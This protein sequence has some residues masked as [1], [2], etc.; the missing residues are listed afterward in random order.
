MTRKE[1]A[2]CSALLVS[3]Y[4][5]EVVEPE[6]LTLYRESLASF[7]A[8][9]VRQAVLEHIHA[10][11][12]FPKISELRDLLIVPPDAPSAE[13]AWGI[14]DKARRSGG[15]YDREILD[16]H[17]P[18]FADERIRQTLEHLGWLGAGWRDFCRSTHPEAD[19]AHFVQWY[20]QTLLH[21]RRVRDREDAQAIN[22]RVV[23][24]MQPLVDRQNQGVL[25]SG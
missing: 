18:K 8:D 14:V 11:K 9:A 15:E 17:P 22:D 19:R 12:W 25:R 5:H 2:I 4:P 13:A 1:W 16:Y 20:N 3:A 24:L 6:Q 7:P 10:S 21:Q 23:A